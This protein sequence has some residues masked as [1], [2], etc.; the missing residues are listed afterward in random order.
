MLVPVI[1]RPA[2]PVDHVSNQY[3]AGGT[4]AGATHVEQQ[5]RGSGRIERLVDELPV[6]E[7][8]ADAGRVRRG[9]E[10]AGGI[11]LRGRVEPVRR[12]DG[13][14]PL[15]TEL[16]LLGSWQR[17]DRLGASVVVAVTVPARGEQGR[18]DLGEDDAAC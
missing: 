18:S 4:L 7:V 10:V 15:A 9:D 11:R 3:E 16:A 13:R 6:H 12:R 5:H 1:V 2:N 17:R 8:D 14:L